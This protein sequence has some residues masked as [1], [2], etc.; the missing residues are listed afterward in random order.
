MKC[1]FPEIHLLC[2]T[3]RLLD[4]QQDGQLLLHFHVLAEVETG[5]GSN[6]RRCNENHS[7]ASGSFLLK[8]K[9]CV[10][11]PRL[12]Y[13]NPGE[14]LFQFLPPLVYI[15]SQYVKYKN[16]NSIFIQKHQEISLIPKQQEVVFGSIQ[17]ILQRY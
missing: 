13:V 8:K 2:Y 9:L 10:N 11:G 12:L 7:T 17:G 16:I 14:F 15:N 4:S 1:T 5:F 6:V 3:C